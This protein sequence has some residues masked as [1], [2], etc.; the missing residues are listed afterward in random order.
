MLKITIPTVRAPVESP[1]K[2]TPL[3]GGSVDLSVIPLV[4]FK[5]VLNAQQYRLR[6][7]VIFSLILL[8]GY[9]ILGPGVSF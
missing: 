2:A 4:Y 6:A 3:A 7:T 8:F 1:I 9:R 5:V